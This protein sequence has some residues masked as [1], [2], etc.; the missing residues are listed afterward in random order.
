VRDASEQIEVL[1]GNGRDGHHPAAI[2]RLMPTA[3]HQLPHL[4]LTTEGGGA[5]ARNPEAGERIEGVRRYFW[6]ELDASRIP[7]ACLDCRAH[8]RFVHPAEPLAWRMGR[9]MRRQFMSLLDG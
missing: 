7:D 4:A 5:I 2:L 1:G 8:V 3:T 6:V 9:W